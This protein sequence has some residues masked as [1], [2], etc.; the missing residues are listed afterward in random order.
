MLASAC[1]GFALLLLIALISTGFDVDD[2]WKVPLYLGGG[3][4]LGMLLGWAGYVIQSHKTRPCP[5]CVSD[6]RQGFVHC[7]VCGFDFGS[8]LPAS[9]QPSE[10][11]SA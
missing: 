10:Q 5:K 9:G 4:V 2:W 7:P 8:L 6:V 3:L 1:F 11:R